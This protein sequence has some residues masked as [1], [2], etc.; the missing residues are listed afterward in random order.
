MTEQK[1]TKRHKPNAWPSILSLAGVMF[2]LGLLGVSILG[3]KGLSSYLI[4]SSS[5][6]LYFQDEVSQQQVIEYQ[7]QVEKLPWVKKTRFITREQ[8]MQEMG[9]TYDPDLMSQVESVSLPLCIEIY[10]KSQFA[11]P[12]FFR[13]KYLEFR[14]DT[15]IEDVIYQA[16]WVQTISENI[17]T[18]QF[19]FGGLAILLMILSV[20][21]IQSSVRLGIF[22]NRF[23]IKSMQ[24]VGATNSFIVRPYI[25]TFVKYAL[26]AIPI[27]GIGIYCIIW[28]IPQFLEEF[29]ILGEFNKHIDT[30]NLMFVSGMIAIF[31]VVLAAA[32]SWL[33]TRKFLRT[34]IEQLY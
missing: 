17:Q 33:S 4:E 21:I 15:R 8:G 32:C 19:I 1:P 12:K 6:D 3:F 16:N 31:G 5:I 9:N 14:K 27:A 2:I 26:F 28:F 30:Q 20:I 29:A 24:L 34:N 18:M 13:Q 11:T 25:L 22:A 7:H 10:P 23:L